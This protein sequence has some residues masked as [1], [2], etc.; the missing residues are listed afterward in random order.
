MATY[1]QHQQEIA[2]ALKE[3]YDKLAFAASEMDVIDTEQ[4][5][6]IAEVRKAALGLLNTIEFAAR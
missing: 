6:R 1:T 3:A 5:Y 2:N 4:A